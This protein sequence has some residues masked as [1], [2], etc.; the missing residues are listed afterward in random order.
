MPTL[1]GNA[2]ALVLAKQRP[3]QPG[4]QRQGPR[5]AQTGASPGLI[6]PWP[7][8]SFAGTKKLAL[9]PQFLRAR[10]QRYQYLATK[11]RRE[12]CAVSGDPMAARLIELAEKFERDAIHDEEEARVLSAEQDAATSES[13]PG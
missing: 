2:R 12:A 13:L 7:A 8:K 6:R 10:A 3:S 4:L 5:L 1:S 9:T 11:A